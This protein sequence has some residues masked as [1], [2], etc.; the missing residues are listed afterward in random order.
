[1]I[2]IAEN[3]FHFLIFYMLFTCILYMHAYKGFAKNI[4][5]LKKI[6]A[7]IFKGLSYI[8]TYITNLRA[9]LKAQFFSKET[10]FL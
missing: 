3:Q 6:L 2:K 4:G 9:N 7:Y 5:L 8:A 10:I 1:M